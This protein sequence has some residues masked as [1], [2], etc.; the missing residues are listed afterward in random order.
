MTSQQGQQDQAKQYGKLVAEA[1][2]DPAFKQR[3][4][5]NPTAVFAER[6]IDVPDGVEIRVVE[7][8]DQA[9][10]FVLPRQPIAEELSDEQIGQ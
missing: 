5:A 4:L 2:R 6:G 9:T 8:T 3:L 1:W 10:Y 7:N